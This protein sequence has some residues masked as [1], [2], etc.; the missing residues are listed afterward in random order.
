[1]NLQSPQYSNNS[2]ADLFSKQRSPSMRNKRIPSAQDNYMCYSNQNL[3]VHKSESPS[4]VYEEIR[5][6]KSHHMENSTN[7]NNSNTKKKIKINTNDQDI[8][9]SIQTLK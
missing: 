3:K 1:M 2:K 9:T 7:S 4:K 8:M 5:R 6:R